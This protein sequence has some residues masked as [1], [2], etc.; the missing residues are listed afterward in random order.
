VEEIAYP[1][2]HTNGNHGVPS[3]YGLLLI[4]YGP[5]QGQARY[6]HRR[7][8]GVASGWISQAVLRRSIFRSMK[9]G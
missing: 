9:A 1:F 3:H 2:P 7:G 8:E 5:A 6:L 4:T